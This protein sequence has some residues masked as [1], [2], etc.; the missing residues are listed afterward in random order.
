MSD[1]NAARLFGQIFKELARNPTVE[2]EQ[3]AHRLWERVGE[4]DFHPCQMCCDEALLTLGL[5]VRHPI[6]GSVGYGPIKK[7]SLSGLYG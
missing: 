2:H 3:I 1:Y 7:R 6:G 4:Y 5:A